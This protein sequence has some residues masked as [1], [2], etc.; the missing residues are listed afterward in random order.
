MELMFIILLARYTFS[1]ANESFSPNI[2]IEYFV[3]HLG[4][5]YWLVYFTLKL[6]EMAMDYA[7]IY[8][9][10]FFT[11]IT[12]ATVSSILTVGGFFLYRYKK[13]MFIYCLYK[14]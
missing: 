11:T 4:C 1:V 14:A 7:V 10:L 6:C 8:R 9:F 5:V 2:L 12:V 3:E 13:P